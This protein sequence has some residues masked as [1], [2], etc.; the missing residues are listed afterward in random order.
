[1]ILIFNDVLFI[2]IVY[3][4]IALHDIHVNPLMVIMRQTVVRINIRRIV[5]LQ[6]LTRMLNSWSLRSLAT[7]IH[8][9]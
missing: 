7:K 1:M 5:F 8:Q 2:C 6:K 4:Y 9:K 3:F